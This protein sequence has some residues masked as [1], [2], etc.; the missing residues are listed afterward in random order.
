MRCA[1]LIAALAALGVA[2]STAGAQ[3]IDPKVYCLRPGVCFAA[4]FQFTDYLTDPSPYTQFTVYLQNLQGSW[5]RR[6][7]GTPYALN[8]FTILTSNPLEE[9]PSRRPTL[10]SQMIDQSDGGTSIGRVR[11]GDEIA[12]FADQ[13]S[14]QRYNSFG[15]YTGYGI[16]GCDF[17]D[18]GRPE[19]FR[20][21]T[22]PAKGLTGWLRFDFHLQWYGATSARPI[23]FD[24]FRYVV[25]NDLEGCTIGTAEV[26]G[27]FNP[28]SCRMHDY[29]EVLR[30]SAI[31][32]PEPTVLAL[33]APGLLAI[34]GVAL[35][36]RTRP[37]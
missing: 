1:T 33:L 7:I 28:G 22:C 19:D 23:R 2:S 10:Y 4:A 16:S 21:A 11:V 6:S 32:T 25:G 26:R 5:P 12:M 18:S 31:A 14:N 36:R 3:A 8:R 13:G 34:G 20:V 24:D 29:D 37:S 30:Q 9:V 15:W 27:I 17:R 35:R